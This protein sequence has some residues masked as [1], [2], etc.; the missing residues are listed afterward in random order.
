MESRNI[1]YIRPREE[2]GE[3]A[4][5]GSSQKAAHRQL[6]SHFQSLGKTALTVWSRKLSKEQV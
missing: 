5:P 3:K 6:R 4:G 1:E 2:G